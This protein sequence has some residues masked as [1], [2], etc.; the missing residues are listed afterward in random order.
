MRWSTALRWKRANS[1]N[2]GATRLTSDANVWSSNEWRSA[3]RATGGREG[4]GVC[5]GWAVGLDV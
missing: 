2:R 3:A 1:I 4:L 5:G